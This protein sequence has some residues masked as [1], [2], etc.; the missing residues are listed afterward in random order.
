MGW[1]TCRFITIIVALLTTATNGLALRR[2]GPLFQGETALTSHTRKAFIACA[3]LSTVVTPVAG[4]FASEVI[5]MP[6]SQRIEG[7]GDGNDLMARGDGPA[8]DVIYP[9]SMA[10][11]WQ[12]QRVVT[13]VDG[14]SAQALG[15][16]RILGGGGGDATFLERKV[17]TYNTGFIQPPQGVASTYDFDG[18]VLTGVVLDRGFEID[19]RVQGAVVQWGAQAP[20]TLVY[21]RRGSGSGSGNQAVELKVVTRKADLGGEGFGF[22]ELVRVT[23]GAGGLFLA[24]QT[25]QRAARVQ[26]RFRRAFSADGKARVVEGLEIVKTYRVLDGIAGELPTSTTKSQLRLVRPP[27]GVSAS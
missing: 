9:A 24:G 7:I 19:S 20:N 6:P 14:D 5:G 17:E 23:T 11:T 16:W 1:P 13:Q 2:Q 12:C 26:R 22:N 4:A 18:D 10:G 3:A 8:N 21:E 15:A 25:V 27:T